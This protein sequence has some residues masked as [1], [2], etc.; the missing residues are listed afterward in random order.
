MSVKA[1][2]GGSLTFRDISFG[3]TA[4]ASN[5]PPVAD[6]GPDNSVVINQQVALAGSG[7]D[8]DLDSLAY[9]WEQVSGPGTATFVDDTDPLTLV[10]FDVVGS[11]VLKLTVDDGTA[12]DDDTMTMTVVIPPLLVNAGPDVTIT[13][14]ATLTL[15]GSHSYGTT[16]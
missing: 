7:T 2:V 9:L 5:T 11:Y 8:A 10:S 4:P 12:T 14:P 16:P 13:L 1:D 3:W 6:A 15:C